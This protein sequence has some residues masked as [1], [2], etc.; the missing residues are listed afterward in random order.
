MCQGMAL[1]GHNENEGNLYQL[2]K[3]RSEDVTALSTWLNIG[4]YRSYDIVN[5]L[6]KIM[7]HKVLCRKQMTIAW[8][9]FLLMYVVMR[10]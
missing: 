3:C 10:G 1:Q 4:Q 6:V 2:L 8:L 7:A 9:K 5:E